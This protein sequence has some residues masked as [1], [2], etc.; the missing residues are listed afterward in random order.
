MKEIIRT[1]NTIIKGDS[2]AMANTTK[3]EVTHL[4]VEEGSLNVSY[5]LTRKI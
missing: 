1:M 2:M 3:I 5:V 4:V